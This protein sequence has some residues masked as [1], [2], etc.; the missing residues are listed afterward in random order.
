MNRKRYR[1]ID[2]QLAKKQGIKS[3]MQNKMEFS[4]SEL[5]TVDKISAG[6]LMT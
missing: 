3:L 1:G 4:D 5:F 2:E 6:I